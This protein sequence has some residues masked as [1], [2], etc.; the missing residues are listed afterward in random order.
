[1]P[2]PVALEQGGAPREAVCKTPSSGHPDPGKTKLKGRSASSPR[3]AFDQPH[4]A[5]RD[6][7]LHGRLP[8]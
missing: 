1:M 6:H 7:H 2:Q 5:A 4:E 8:G 3:E